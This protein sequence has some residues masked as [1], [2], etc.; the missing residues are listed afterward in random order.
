MF[1]PMLFIT[2]LAVAAAVIMLYVR[3][4]EIGSG[5]DIVRISRRSPLSP[6]AAWAN[7][8]SAWDKSALTFQP[9]AFPPTR[10]QGMR[11]VVSTVKGRTTERILKIVPTAGSMSVGYR[12]YRQEDVEYP[13]GEN[14]FERWSVVPA[15]EGSRIEVTTQGLWAPVAAG[16]ALLNMWRKAGLIA[17]GKIDRTIAEFRPRS[18]PSRPNLR[19]RKGLATADAYFRREAIISIA[20]VA[21]LLVQFSWQSAIV[22]AALIL[23]HEYGHLLSYQLTGKKGNRLMLVPFFG[24]IAVAGA[25]HKNEFERA[26]CALAGPGICTL[27]TIGA[28]AVC[29]FSDNPSVLFWSWDVVYFSAILNLLN[30]L[31]IYPLDGGHATESFSRSYFPAHVRIALIATSVA[32]LLTVLGMG[33]A[34]TALFFGVFALTSLKTLPEHARLRTMSASEAIQITLA[35]ALIAAVHL[36]G[37]YAYF[38]PVFRL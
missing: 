19:A 8:Q 3:L 28:L 27:T 12:I 22:L 7:L 21:V 30:L 20:A 36:F 26:F 37:Y 34:Q 18:M 10:Q 13:F 2:C 16:M 38:N 5:K 6:E 29:H 4:A 35:Y 23:F 9:A 33:Y 11:M 24:G 14:H 15:A 25:P 31:P 17:S 1:I 32:G